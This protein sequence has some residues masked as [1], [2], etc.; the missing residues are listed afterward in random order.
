MGKL[1]SVIQILLAFLFC[2]GL[3]LF[4]YYL[5]L[6]AMLADVSL[7]SGVLG[8]GGGRPRTWGEIL[9]IFVGILLPFFL[10]P[11]AARFLAIDLKSTTF[12]AFLMP[13]FFVAFPLLL[14]ILFVIG[15]SVWQDYITW[16]TEWHPTNGEQRKY[17]D[18]GDLQ[19]ISN[20]TNGKKS[21]DY[22]RYCQ[23]GS[24]SAKGELEN[25]LLIGD[26]FLRSRCDKGSSENYIKY[27]PAGHATDTKVLQNNHLTF[28]KT[29]KDGR[30]VTISYYPYDEKVG[31][32]RIRQEETAIYATSENFEKQYNPDGSLH[33]EKKSIRANIIE[34]K[35]YDRPK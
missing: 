26:Y 14:I 28:L 23:D 22:I 24:V 17:F 15:S 30:E 11:V 16:R 31:K 19:E 9:I 4:G 18:N 35:W 13:V 1:T 5:A 21:G 8:P 32:D 12:F 27:E 33:Y 3:S 2:C 6:R 25:G 7:F 29:I 34:E 20:W 10:F